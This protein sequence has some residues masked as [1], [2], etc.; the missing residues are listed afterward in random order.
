MTKLNRFGEPVRKPGPDNGPRGPLERARRRVSFGGGKEAVLPQ[1][2]EGA[3][4]L[5]LRHRAGGE[6]QAS[7]GRSF[8]VT[9][10]DFHDTK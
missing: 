10:P 5:W 6:S 9:R 2:R 4:A 8:G 7:I 3:Y 1:D